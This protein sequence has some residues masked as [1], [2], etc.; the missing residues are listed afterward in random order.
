MIDVPLYGKRIRRRS[1]GI[2][3][4]TAAQRMP[5]VGS[6]RTCGIDRGIPIEVLAVNAVVSVIADLGAVAYTFSRPFFRSGFCCYKSALGSLRGLGDNVD[7]AVDGIR[8]PQGGPGTADDFDAVHILEHDVLH[9]PVHTRE[10]RGVDAS[11]VNQNEQ[12]VVESPVEPSRADGPFVLVDARHFQA[13]NHPQSIRDAGRPGA[14]DIFLCYH[15]DRC[16]SEE[17]T[18]ELQ[19]R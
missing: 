14:A 5:A 15:E 11:A 19:S 10:K 1:I 13:W 9:V 8:A 18:S 4:E 17:H 7:H 2:N 16:R 3:T 6:S 12:L